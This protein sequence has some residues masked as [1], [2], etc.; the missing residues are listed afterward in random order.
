MIPVSDADRSKEFYERLGWRLDADPST[1]KFRII[2]FTPTGSACSVQF[3][4]TS[5]RLSPGSAR[6]LLLS[7]PTSTPPTTTWSHVTSRVSDVF[8]CSTGSVCRSEAPTRAIA[9]PDR[10]RGCQLRLL[11]FVQRSR[12]QWLAA[13][14]GHDAA[15]GRTDT[16]FDLLPL[17][18][19]SGRRAAAGV[20]R[21]RRAREAHRQGRPQLARLV[22]RLHG[23]R[24][25]GRGTASVSDEDSRSGT[26]RPLGR[27]RRSIGRHRRLG[28]PAV[29]RRGVNVVLV[30]RRRTRSR[31][32]RRRSR[33]RPGPSC[34]ISATRRRRPPRRRDR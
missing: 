30:A 33:P 3:G 24:A 12:R 15:P 14:G 26:L 8:H 25:I 7:S 23:A 18:A 1:A 20:G 10:L 21:P 6:A 4:T 9:H 13:A 29:G 22:C 11:R 32:S 31:R 16:D 2:Q 5:P 17:D 34:S 27:G 19:R 28:R